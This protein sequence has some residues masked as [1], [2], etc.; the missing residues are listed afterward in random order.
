MVQRAYGLGNS[1]VPSIEWE[2]IEAATIRRHGGDQEQRER[3][4]WLCR[5]TKQAAP[6]QILDLVLA[7]KFGFWKG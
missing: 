1:W 6:V 3:D 5:A 7:F 4:G 2:S